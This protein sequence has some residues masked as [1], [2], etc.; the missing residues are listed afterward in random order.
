M[1]LASVSSRCTL[2]SAAAEW[3]PRGIDIFAGVPMRGFR[4]MRRAF[5][6]R[7]RGLRLGNRSASA[8]KSG[9]PESVA[10]R[11]ASILANSAASRVGALLV[12]AQGGLQLVAP[13]GEVGKRAGQFGKGFFRSRECGI[14]GGDATVGAGELR[15]GFLRDRG[16]RLLFGVEPLSAACGVGGQRPLA[17]EVGRELLDAAIEFADAFLGAGFLA[18]QRLA[19]DDEALQTGG[20]RGFGFAQGRQPGGDL[21]LAGGGLRV[22]AGARRN[23]ANGLVL[24]A[25]G[26]ADFAARRDPAQMEQQ[27]FGAAHLAGNIAV[28]HRLPR[29]GFQRRDLGGEL[30]DDVLDPR[31]VLPR[32]L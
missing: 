29:L 13:C 4:G 3:R 2:R 26:F 11:P 16:Q 19:R 18:F 22:F 31:Q 24:G 17:G 20:G 15:V 27:R 6:L 14:R 23:H 30:A 12:F 1:V 5:R 10:A 28:A 25:A 8:A 32:P 21:R 7:E 9:A